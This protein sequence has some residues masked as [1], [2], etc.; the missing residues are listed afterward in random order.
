MELMTAMQQLRATEVSAVFQGRQEQRS[1]VATNRAASPTLPAQA[2]HQAQL[3]QQRNRLEPATSE[4]ADRQPVDEEQALEETA[5]NAYQTVGMVKRILEQLSSRQIELY[6]LSPSADKPQT[7]PT[8]LANN[9][10]LIRVTEWEFGY[11]AV[12]ASFSGS[13]QLANGQQVSWDLSFQMKYSWASVSSRTLL[14]SELQDP[15]VISLNGMPAQLTGDSFSFDLFN[16]GVPVQLPNLAAQQFYLGLDKTGNGRIESGAELFGPR[17]GEG[18]AE[19][20]AYD[21]DG[22]G[23]ID[24]QDAIWQNLY[25][26]RPDGQQ[27]SMAEAQIGAVSVQSVPTRM[28]LFFERSDQ[29]GGMLQRSSVYLNTSGQAGL[30]QQI[31][32]LV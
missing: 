10:E 16:T 18:F 11:Q 31:D 22:N 4:P 21:L 3:A 30:V 29:L 32:L 24:Q 5:F 27:L 23:F 8:E 25:L 2:A 17:T 15:L 26:W 7:R 14:A 12:S 1:Q 19:L 6:Q 20:A 9:N 13:A 28:P